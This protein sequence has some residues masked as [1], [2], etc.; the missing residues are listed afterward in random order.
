MG[1]KKPQPQSQPRQQQRSPTVPDTQVGQSSYIRRQSGMKSGG[2]RSI[3][4]GA[5]GA[6]GQAG[7]IRKSLLGQ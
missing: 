3:Y 2:G 1:S 6:S 5:L 7:V 4:T